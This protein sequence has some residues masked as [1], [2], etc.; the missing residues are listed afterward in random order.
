MSRSL[1]AALRPSSAPPMDHERPMVRA[2]RFWS[3]LGAQA[4]GS[5]ADNALRAAAIV[6]I[7]A[8]YR[9]GVQAGGDFHAP[10][11]LAAEAGTYVGLCFTVPI[12]VFSMISGQIADR[13]D[14]HVIIRVT[15]V[16]EVILMLIASVFF[17]L[18]NALGLLAFLFLMG[19]QSSF[20]APTRAAMMPQYFPGRELMRANGYFHGG[21]LIA[22]VLG[23]GIGGALIV[24]S[25]GRYLVSAVLV[26][27][28]L[29]GMIAAFRTPAA[30]APGLARVN[31]NVFSQAW[32][33][34][35]DVWRMPGVFWPMI[36]V[37]WFWGIGA[38]TLANLENFVSALGGVSGDFTAFQAIF[39]I[40]AGLGSVAAG[41]IANRMRDPMRLAG[42]GVAGTIACA[43]AVVAVARVI[44]AG[45]GPVPVSLVLNPTPI[46]WG[47]AGLIV[48]TAAFNGFFVV[49]LLT[50]LQARAP[51][52]ERARVLGT[53]NMTNGGM[54]TFMALLVPASRPLGFDPITLWVGVAG[55][56]LGVLL[57]MF[58]RLR[59]HEPEP[60]TGPGAQAAA[61]D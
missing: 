31:W 50:A 61:F 51:E 28:A 14:R 60:V 40:G 33:M 42:V 34:Y 56:Q 32:R 45:A 54:A 21:S 23:L 16:I 15:K 4:L 57:F 5:F 55:L 41:V 26:T 25:N 19:A 52:H 53:A 6:A 30:P 37:G 8:A 59:T 43:L 44:A 18:G 58:H 1:A 20:L 17:A 49:P 36:G 27:A 3:L 47:L 29:A 12:F 13:Y 2:R 10:A 7:A 38:I 9:T 39:A 46:L 11:W 35:R 24:L 48:A 22:I